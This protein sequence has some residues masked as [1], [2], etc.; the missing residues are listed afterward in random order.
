MVCHAKTCL[1]DCSHPSMQHIALSRDGVIN[2]HIAHA[3]LGLLVTTYSPLSIF[4][5]PTQTTTKVFMWVPQLSCL[6]AL[7][8][9]WLIFISGKSDSLHLIFNGSSGLGKFMK[10]NLIHFSLKVYCDF[11]HSCL[12]GLRLFFIQKFHL[13][14]RDP[15][16]PKVIYKMKKGAVHI[17]TQHQ[18]WQ[19]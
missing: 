5:A 9:V 4:S 17:I 19:F 10:K 13:D 7:I 15:T 11:F 2:C 16:Q 6:F 8:N 1:K 14:I 3:P 18:H 12:Q